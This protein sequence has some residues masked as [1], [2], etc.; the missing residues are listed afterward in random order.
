MGCLHKYFYL[1]L[2]CILH[3]DWLLYEPKSAICD[4]NA[5]GAAECYTFPNSTTRL[6]KHKITC[7][8]CINL[9]P[10]PLKITEIHHFTPFSA[11]F[12]SVRGR[13]ILWIN[14]KHSFKQPTNNFSSIIQL[15]RLILLLFHLTP[16]CYWIYNILSF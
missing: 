2:W 6:I 14:S 3:D 15:I 4:N 5:W 10:L 16:A 8:L 11:Y 7:I 9:I 12:R 13:Y 1:E